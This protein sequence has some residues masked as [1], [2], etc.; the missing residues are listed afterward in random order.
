MS[1]K[2]KTEYVLEL[3]EREVQ[4]LKALLLDAVNWEQEPAAQDIFDALDG[5]CRHDALELV[6]AG[7][8]NNDGY[9]QL[10]EL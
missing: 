3:T 5:V 4:V 7:R 1:K 6:L 9:G 10:T 2:Q 8:E